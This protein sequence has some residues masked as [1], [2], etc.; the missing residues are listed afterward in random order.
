MRFGVVLI[1][2]VLVL[3][4]GC[5]LLDLLSGPS[6][7]PSDPYDE[8]CNLKPE[9]QKD[10]KKYSDFDYRIPMESR[11]YEA[12]QYYKA[13]D[14]IA[15]KS[16]KVYELER[17]MAIEEV[18]KQNLI[19]MK[20]AVFI[21]NK[22]NLVKAFIRLSYVTAHTIVKASQAGRSYGDM[23][24]DPTKNGVQV[25]GEVIK[26]VDHLDPPNSAIAINTN[27]TRGK[28]NEVAR[29][30]W[31]ETLTSFGDGTAT[32]TAMAKKALELATKAPEPKL[33]EA[34]FAILKA[35][36]QEMKRLD[37][38]IQNSDAR[39][40]KMLW[41]KRAL[42]QQI[43]YLKSDLWDY[44]MDEKERTDS[45]LIAECERIKERMEE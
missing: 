2:L 25:L 20:Q 38:E 31:Q 35:E 17:D 23:L 21:G 36:Y 22:K 6:I 19:D 4:S 12:Q 15:E 32:G 10:W 18:A 5:E 33:S 42:E 41:E 30:G 29:A 39:L 24:V 40:F 3:T 43:T 44:E 8:N 26:A 16:A 11:S 45:M 14:D 37:A 7:D 28:V 34:D 13:V 1:V 9:Y 27:T